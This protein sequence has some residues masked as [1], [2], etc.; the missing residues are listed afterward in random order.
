MTD[1]T[2]PAG[3]RIVQGL[4]IALTVD[5]YDRA[6]A[7]YRD[8]LGLTEVESW[9]RPDGRGTI[10]DAGR[11]TLEL[12]DPPQAAT[13]DAIEVGRRV[14]GPVRFALRVDDSV[15][16]AEHLIARGATREGD[17]VATPWGDRKVRVHAPDGMQLT[18]F[19]L[20][21]GS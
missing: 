10:L 6:V 1:D 8:A 21:E 16:V 14:S 17:L 11:A 4:R 2:A 19:S 13:L 7:F 9:V 5:D 12:F 18:L 3:P 15:R 20:G